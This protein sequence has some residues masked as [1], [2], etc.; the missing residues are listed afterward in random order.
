MQCY[1][2]RMMLPT[3]MPNAMLK[4][5]KISFNH[6]CGSSR[7]FFASA[8]LPHDLL[9]MLPLPAP[10]KIKCFRVRFQLFSKCFHF[11]KNLAA[12]TSLVS[13]AFASLMTCLNNFV[14]KWLLKLTF[15]GYIAFGSMTLF[16]L[17]FRHMH[18]VVTFFLKTT[19]QICTNL[20]KH[21][22]IVICEKP[23]SRPLKGSAEI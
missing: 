23:C 8:S 13:K 6:G 1:S 20:G 7:L 4:L 5:V 3:T 22:F 2:T 11:H 16:F 14:C 19:A 15:T 21:L 12:S 9:K 10:Q 17:I 18:A